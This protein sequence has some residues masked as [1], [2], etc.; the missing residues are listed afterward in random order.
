MWWPSGK[1]FVRKTNI[2]GSIP[3]HISMKPEDYI[4]N[5]LS[6]LKSET[7][8]KK[9]ESLS[10]QELEEFIFKSLMSKKF[11]K[12][13]VN[14]DYIPKIK[15]AIK[16]SV[17]NKLPIKLAFPFGAYKLWRLEESPEVDWAELFT[18]MY[19]TKWVKGISEIYK[20]GI[21]IDF[22]SDAVIVERMNNIPKSDT[23]TYDKSFNRL[24]SFLEK[25]LSDNIKI[26][27]TQVGSFYTEEEFNKDLEDKISAMKKE[28]GGLPKLNEKTTA[29]VEL[30]V[31]L[32]PDQDKDPLWR[33]KVEL[34]HQAYYAV[35]KRR[36][37][38]RAPEKILIFCTKVSNCISVGT[39][40][41]SIA[42]FW[43]GSGALKKTKD[44]YQEYVL[45]PSQSKTQ[46]NF[47]PI[48][49][50]GLSGKNFNKIRII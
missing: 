33:E 48:K 20:P 28:W 45:S 47:E 11:R 19:F 29:M 14:V 49:I 26:T 5:K 17:E 40:K 3:T 37:Y 35:S 8:S 41:T 10:D 50:E 1:A 4:L 31:K 44:S 30:N 18:L 9:V 21:W 36:P 13:A 12:F 23:D 32:K 15:W 6:H 38:S 27:L 46:N 42:K 22:V 24:L 2:V 25:Y 16:N 39:T 34:L 43:A 7:T